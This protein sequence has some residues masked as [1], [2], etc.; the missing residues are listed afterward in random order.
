MISNLPSTPKFSQPKISRANIFLTTYFIV[1]K[2]HCKYY[3]TPPFLNHL[4]LSHASFLFELIWKLSLFLTNLETQIF[5]AAIS[6][7][8]ICWARHEQFSFHSHSFIARNSIYVMIKGKK[9][10]GFSFSLQRTNKRDMF[11][12]KATILSLSRITSRI[13]QPRLRFFFSFLD[14]YREMYY[15]SFFTNFIIIVVVLILLQ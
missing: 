6:F 11:T 14:C 13:Q 5:Q 1:Y 9:Y 12:S 2:S 3:L 7:E 15:G 4:S 8:E 10:D